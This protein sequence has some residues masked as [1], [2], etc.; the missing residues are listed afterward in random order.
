LAH[1]DS[2]ASLRY[3]ILQLASTN[4]LRY[5]TDHIEVLSRWAPTLVDLINTSACAPPNAGLSDVVAYVESRVDA[6]CAGVPV[7]IELLT[8]RTLAEPIVE[9]S[10]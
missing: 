1:V 8:T 2:C 4:T 3:S 5:T 10:T 9:E 6:R 7:G